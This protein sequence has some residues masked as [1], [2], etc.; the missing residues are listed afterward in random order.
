MPI[1][2]T[3]IVMGY[4]WFLAAARGTAPHSCAERV[5]L[6][7]RRRCGRSRAVRRLPLVTVCFSDA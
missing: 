2:S 7:D 5:E 1:N 3:R 6:P 4:T